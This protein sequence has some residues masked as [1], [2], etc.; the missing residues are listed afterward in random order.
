M[1]AQQDWIAGN[2]LMQGVLLGLLCED[3]AQR[4]NG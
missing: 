2:V 4:D 3:F 1:K